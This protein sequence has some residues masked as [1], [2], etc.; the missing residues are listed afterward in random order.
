MCSA[1][2][3]ADPDLSFRSQRR[4]PPRRDRRAKAICAGRPVRSACLGFAMA[5][6]DLEGIWGGTTHEERG[7]PAGQGRSEARARR[8]A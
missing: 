4:P 8:A 5:D 6:R 2:P 1:A 3:F 7:R